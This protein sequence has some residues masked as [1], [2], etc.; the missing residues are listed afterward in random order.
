MDLDRIRSGEPKYLIRE[1]MEKKY[2][3]I[4]VP[5]KLPMPRPVE[6]YFRNWSGPKR[7]EFK[8]GLDMRLYTGDQKWQ[9]WCL[10]EFLNMNEEL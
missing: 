4:P 6:E 8:K 7:P 2:P 9:M 5:N 3:E 10:E 1:L